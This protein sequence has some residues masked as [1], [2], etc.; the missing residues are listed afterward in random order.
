MKQL[1]VVAALVCSTRVGAQ[2]VDSNSVLI[3]N[4]TV[5]P[6]TGPE[7]QNTSV[8]ILDGRIAEIG[9]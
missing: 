3:R 9:P 2:P 1:C 6:V 5:H 7:I 8:L 4:A